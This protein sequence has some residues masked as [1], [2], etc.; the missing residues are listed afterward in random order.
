MQKDEGKRNCKEEHLT[1][2]Y[3]AT[4]GTRES[5]AHDQVRQALELGVIRAPLYAVSGEVMSDETFG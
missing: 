3:G 5:F 1:D 2:S 4:H